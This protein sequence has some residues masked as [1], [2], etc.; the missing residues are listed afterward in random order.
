MS[1]RTADCTFLVVPQNLLLPDF[2]AY[3]PWPNNDVTTGS[4]ATTR[5][6]SMGSNL[7]TTMRHGSMPQS[8]PHTPSRRG[9]VPKA[10][11]SEHSEVGSR[12]CRVS[13]CVQGLLC[14]LII[15]V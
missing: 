12:G 8:S 1:L 3:D 10:Q 14:I 2:N 11:D 9:G 13:P 4:A 15:L 6:Q 7:V 5:A